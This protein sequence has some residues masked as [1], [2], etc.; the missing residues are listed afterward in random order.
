MTTIH[1]KL[2]QQLFDGHVDEVLHNQKKIKFTFVLL[3]IYNYFNKY[4][5]DIPNLIVGNFSDDTKDNYIFSTTFHLLLLNNTY[6]FI[7]NNLNEPIILQSDAILFYINYQNECEILFESNKTLL[8]CIECLIHIKSDYISEMMLENC[9]EYLNLDF[10]H[11]EKYLYV[12]CD[13]ISNYYYNWPTSKQYYSSLNRW[14]MDKYTISKHVYEF[15]N[16]FQTRMSKLTTESLNLYIKLT[17]PMLEDS[18]DN[19]VEIQYEY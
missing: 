5:P 4:H 10:K 7:N 14:T 17:T 3:E 11:R 18:E 12:L 9:L 15:V 1:D 16:R 19:N 6:C 13:V 2:N 8:Y